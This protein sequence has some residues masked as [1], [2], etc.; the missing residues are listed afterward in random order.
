MPQTLPACSAARESDRFTLALLARTRYVP[1]WSM[2]FDLVNHKPRSL[3]DQSFGLLSRAAAGATRPTD[4]VVLAL[5]EQA[6]RR[7][8]NQGMGLVPSPLHESP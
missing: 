4:Y 6:P 2:R 3:R 8:P 5:D 7:V 1:S